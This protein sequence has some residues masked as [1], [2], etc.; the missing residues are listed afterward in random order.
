MGVAEDIIGVVP[1]VIIGKVALD[2][3]N[4]AFGEKKR[5]ARKSSKK[6]TRKSK[7]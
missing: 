3:T 5:K 6:R 7:R 4:S 1:T 2:F